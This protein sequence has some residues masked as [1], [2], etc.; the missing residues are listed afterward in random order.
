MFQIIYFWLYSKKKKKKCF[1]EIKDFQNPRVSIRSWAEK[2]DKT[3]LSVH[4]HPFEVIEV[5]VKD[6]F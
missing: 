6:I 3:T 4:D 1:A 2:N 5:S